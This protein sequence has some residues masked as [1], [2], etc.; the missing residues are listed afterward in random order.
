MSGRACVD[1]KSVET[2]G[3]KA[4]AK[5]WPKDPKK[6]YMDWLTVMK[7]HISGQSFVAMIHNTFFLRCSRILVI[8]TSILFA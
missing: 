4:L 3:T 2:G 1:A 7:L 5:L 6:A 8:L